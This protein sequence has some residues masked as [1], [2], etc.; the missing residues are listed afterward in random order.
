M[1]KVEQIEEQ[2]RELS[3]GEFLELREWVL[4]QLPAAI[5]DP[6]CIHLAKLHLRFDQQRASDEPGAS[7][8]AAAKFPNYAK[9][10]IPASWFG[11]ISMKS[12]INARCN[13]R[14]ARLGY[15]SR[16]VATPSGMALPPT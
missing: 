3:A 9:T 1:R 2:I 13:R 12:P 8:P 11:T 7:L 15:F 14:F 16:Q 10:Y 4:E 6:L 5:L